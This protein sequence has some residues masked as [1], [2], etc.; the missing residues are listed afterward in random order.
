M[1][2]AKSFKSIQSVY[3][4]N[5]KVR[6]EGYKIVEKAFSDK[7]IYENLD[8]MKKVFID[9]CPKRYIFDSYSV[10]SASLMMDSAVRLQ[11]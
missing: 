2:T 8:L 11:K 10:L 7:R 9:Y 6:D 4:D 5:L 3:H 1:I